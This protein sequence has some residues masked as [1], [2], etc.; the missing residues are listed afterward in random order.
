MPRAV[1]DHV[2]FHMRIAPIQRRQTVQGAIHTLLDA[3]T[4]DDADHQASRRDPQTLPGL[5]RGAP[6]LVFA[7]I[8]RVGHVVQPLGR[9]ARVKALAGQQRADGDHLLVVVHGPQVQA[10]V[11]ARAPCLTCPTMGGGHQPHRPQRPQ[12]QPQ[13]VRLVVVGVPDGDVLATAQI[14]QRTQHAQIQRAGLGD[15]PERA[16]QCGGPAAQ[17]FDAV[18][19]AWVQIDRPHAQPM[20]VGIAGRAQDGLVRPAAAARHDARVQNHRPRATE[21][22]ER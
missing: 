3:Q 15:G 13:Q 4:P 17:C 1:A 21:T 14:E 11:R 8:N 19:A 20:R 6:A 12:Q 18:V 22:G 9:D 7:H 2:Q 16:V 10:A 5:G